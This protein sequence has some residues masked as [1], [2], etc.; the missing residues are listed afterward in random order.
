MTTEEEMDNSQKPEGSCC[1]KCAGFY[2]WGDENGRCLCCGFHWNPTIQPK[3][4]KI[5]HCC[6]G[7]CVKPIDRF[8]QIFCPT[9]AREMVNAGARKNIQRQRNYT[10]RKGNQEEGAIR[11]NAPIMVKL[12][13]HHK[14]TVA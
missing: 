9:H 14:K 6:F 13:S 7:Q 8:E 1:P 5:P 2:L 3:G 11:L 10:K 12:K 4:F